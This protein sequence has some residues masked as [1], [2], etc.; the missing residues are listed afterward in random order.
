MKRI[1]ALLLTLTLALPLVACNKTK[2]ENKPQDGGDETPL[3]YT[4]KLDPA[5]TE[6]NFVQLEMDSGATLV[7][8]LYPE[9]APET[10]ANFKKLVAEGFYNGKTFHRLYEGF[11]I[12]GGCPNGDGTGS[13]TPIKGEFAANGFTQ[14]TLAH[15]RGVISMARRTDPDSGSCQFFIMHQ[16]STSLDGKYAAFGRVVAGMETVDYLATLPVTQQDYSLEKTK[17]VKAPVIKAATFVNY[18]AE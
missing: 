6:T 16:K 3:Y 18:V 17:P 11:M 10:V 14:N 5:A 4:T 7:V 12:Q 1:L 9:F 2:N 15:D 13:T 8:A